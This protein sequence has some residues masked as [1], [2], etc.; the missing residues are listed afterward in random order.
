[1]LIGS[2]NKG[3]KNGSISSSPLIAELAGTAQSLSAF[4]TQYRFVLL[5]DSHMS[6]SVRCVLTPAPNF[7]NLKI[8]TSLIA[9]TLACSACISQRTRRKFTTPQ[10]RLSC[11]SVQYSFVVC[12]H[13]PPPPLSLSLSPT[14]THTHTHTTTTTTISPPHSP[15][16]EV[17][18]CARPI[19]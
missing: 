6:H 11:V 17:E 19:L 2:W 18:L 4:N 7:T 12:L 13:H 3:Q 8:C 14:H 10:L 16:F 9:A 5:P 1:M 15:S